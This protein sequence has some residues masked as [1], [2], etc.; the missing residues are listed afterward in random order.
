MSAAE[1]PVLNLGARSGPALSL[2]QQLSFS[3]DAICRRLLAERLFA[4][5]S[6]GLTLP[7]HLTAHWLEFLLAAW[8]GLAAPWAI[9][10]FICF[11]VAKCDSS[12]AARLKPS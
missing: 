7:K 8:L 12:T 2:Q 5:Y 4:F 6:G 3:C 10:F 1:F 11:G 9:L